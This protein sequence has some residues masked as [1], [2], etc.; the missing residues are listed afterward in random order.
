MYQEN[1]VLDM[2]FEMIEDLFSNEK[3]SLE[4]KM[5]ILKNLLDL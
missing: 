4:Q 3:F 1:F 5:C 2:Q